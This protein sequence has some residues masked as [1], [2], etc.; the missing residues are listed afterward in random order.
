MSWT[1]YLGVDVQLNFITPG[2]A[3]LFWHCGVSAVGTTLILILV[4]IGSSF[5][6]LYEGDMD[7]CPKD[8]MEWRLA[9]LVKPW[10]RATPFLLG[11]LLAFWL[12]TVGDESG[13]R[14]LPRMRSWRRFIMFLSVSYFIFFF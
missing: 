5:I 4:S 3:L 14:N 8:Y 1:W 9:T 13:A 10:M 7:A 6:E 12:N 11:F 2:V